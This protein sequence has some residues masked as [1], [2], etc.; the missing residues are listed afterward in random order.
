MPK[1]KIKSKKTVVK[2]KKT[3]V[4]QK[5]PFI[6]TTQ[7]KKGAAAVLGLSLAALALRSHLKKKKS[8]ESDSDSDD[9]DFR[10]TLGLEQKIQQL[11]NQIDNLKIEINKEKQS[12]ITLVNQI[13]QCNKEVIRQR[14]VI[15]SRPSL[16]KEAT[17]RST[18]KKMYKKSSK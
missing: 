18:I 14:G 16:L 3:P 13:N 11:N 4:T 7:L 5:K 12:N 2:S 9:E 6:S 15:S 10:N 8:P 17:M 1:T